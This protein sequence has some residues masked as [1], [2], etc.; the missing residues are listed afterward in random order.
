[1]LSTAVVPD[2]SSRRYSYAAVLAAAALGAALPGAAANVLAPLLAVG[3]VVFGIAHGACDQ[4]ILP[5]AQSSQQ[6]SQAIAVWRNW[7]YMGWFLLV[8]LGLA[9]VVVGLWWA[10]PAPSVALFFLLTVWHWGSA[11]APAAHETPRF[12]LLHSLLRGLL[13]FAM[14]SL[15]W[16]TETLGIVNSLLTFAGAQPVSAAVFGPVA[17]VLTLAVGV[18]HLGLWASFAVSR[19]K[20]VLRQDAQEVALLILLF[21]ALP[22]V[23]SVGV[24]FVFWHSL[25]H[26]QRLVPLLGYAAPAGQFRPARELLRQMGFF[27]RRAAPLLLVSCTALLGLGYVF[28]ARL[29]NGAAWF[30]LALVVASVVTLPHALLVT[31]V[32]DAS[33]WRPRKAT[34][35]ATI[36]E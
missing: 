12:W 22:P 10:W 20:A 27:L 29:P 23:L 6:V 36:A 16:P 9:G 35:T 1:M 21:A 4:L 34:P 3:L 24:Y 2:F 13:V 26:V 17:T 8:Y 31:F 18:G 25:Q 33:R 30:S 28:S 14:P 11:D 15:R 5:A 19:Q 32:M 7:R